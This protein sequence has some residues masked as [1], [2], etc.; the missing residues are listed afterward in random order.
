M[1]LLSPSPR[2]AI[3]AGAALGHSGAYDA[4][5]AAEVVRAATAKEEQQRPSRALAQRSHNAL[6]P[7]R[8]R[9]RR[10][11]SVARNK[12][13]EPEVEREEAGPTAATATPAETQP[14]EFALLTR[15]SEFRLVELQCAPSSLS[16]CPVS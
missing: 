15:R 14:R 10:C 2:T 11:A 8:A 13:H 6:R 12:L 7:R 3:S 9:E 5:D 4:A 16:N 1:T